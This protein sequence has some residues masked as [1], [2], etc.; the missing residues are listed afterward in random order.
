[1]SVNA[2]FDFAE[3]I[4]H[5][6]FSF[7]NCTE[8][9]LT[10]QFFNGMRDDQEIFDYPQELIYSYVIHSLKD[11]RLKTS[12]Q[13]PPMTDA[14]F[15][16]A[17]YSDADVSAKFYTYDNCPAQLCEVVGWTDSP[18][19][20]GPGMLATYIIQAILATIYLVAIVKHQ[21][22]PSAAHSSIPLT[23]TLA[24][25]KA[26]TSDFLLASAIFSVAL[27]SASIF[28]IT[29]AELTPTFTSW[30]LELVIPI[31]SVLPVIILNL[32]AADF[33]PRE[34]GRTIL[35]LVI[36]ALTVALAARSPFA[37]GGKSQFDLNND[38]TTQVEKAC[39]VSDSTKPMATFA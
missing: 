34:K 6:D 35:W 32:A 7:S 38:N 21:R 4:T 24:A 31:N 30:G 5:E 18:D 22:Y 39:T 10:W 9:S 16:W 2:T 14:F 1:M 19:L 33:L 3:L 17:F 13:A 26:S 28:S 23:R 27:L 29:R 25:A 37:F 36:G 20:A 15:S 12:L 11:W 8:A